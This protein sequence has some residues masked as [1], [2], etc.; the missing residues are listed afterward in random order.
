METKKAISIEK[1]NEKIFSRN[2]SEVSEGFFEFL[3]QSVF[4]CYFWLKI[5]AAFS[6]KEFFKTLVQKL[7]MR[8]E[9]NVI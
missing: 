4:F 3:E 6:K 7:K 5:I 8:K 2:P 9:K 1:T